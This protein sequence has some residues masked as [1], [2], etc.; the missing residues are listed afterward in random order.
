MVQTL[1]TSWSITKPSIWYPLKTLL[2]VS[3]EGRL[4]ALEDV[5]WGEL[6]RR[7][8][9]IFSGEQKL[10]CIESIVSFVRK[11]FRR[12]NFSEGAT[13]PP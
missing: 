13:I 9:G 6:Q 4:L 8:W 3:K 7:L 2:Q 11:H 1:G 12:E 5:H 10:R